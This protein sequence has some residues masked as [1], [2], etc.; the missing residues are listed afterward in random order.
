MAGQD[1]QRREILR[2]MAIAAAAAPFP[3]FTKWAFA[4]GHNSHGIEQIRPAKYQPQFFSAREY[5]VVER[6]A[7]LIIPSDQTP[8]AREAGVAEFVDFMISRDRDQQYKF[9]TGISWLNAH[10]ERL[11]GKSFVELSEK[12]QIAILEPLAYKAKYREGEEDGRDFFRRMKEM[13]TMGF[14]TTEIGYKELDNPALKFYAESPECPHKD[15]PE[16]KH[17]PPPKW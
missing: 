12:D 5:A 10:S 17:L 4:F 9:R 15:D 6:L 1:L 2:I 11:L 14:Y 16:H 3:G 7:D 8:G 13:T